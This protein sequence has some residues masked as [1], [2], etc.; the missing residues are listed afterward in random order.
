VNPAQDRPNIVIRQRWWQRGRKPATVVFG[1]LVLG[2]LLGL[3]VG[4]AM[5]WRFFRAPAQVALTQATGVQV[6]LEGE[7]GL[8]LFRPPL[9]QIE[10]LQ[11]AAA[12]GVPAGYLLRAS[13]VTLR[14]RWGDV[15]RAWRGG[16]IVIA[17]LGAQKLD[18]NLIRLMNGSATWQIGP[19]ANAQTQQ[20][21]AEPPHIDAFSL[22]EGLLRV[23]DEPVQ[24]RA[25]I[26][27]ESDTSGL[28][29]SANAVGTLRALSL[30]LHA[31]AEG[32][33]SEFD[34]Q[35]ASPTAPS[36]LQDAKSFAVRVEG[37]VGRSALAWAGQFSRPD[38][39]LA[40][41]GHLQFR[42]PSLAAVGDP[43]HISLPRTP[44]FDIAGELSFAQ[45]RWQLSESKLRVGSSQL[46][47]H[48]VFDTNPQPALL[49][50]RLTGS[51]LLFTDLAPAIGGAG[52]GG[53]EGG[54]S[55]AK[56]ASA[57]ST[58]AARVLPDRALDFSALRQMDADL[59][60]DIASVDFGSAAV[61]PL[62][63][64]RTHLRLVKAVLALESLQTDV[65]GGHLSGHTELDGRAD[66]AAWAG[67]LQF[68]GLDL[69]GFVRAVNVAPKAV[70][71][72]GGRAQ[73]QAR[74]PAD[75]IRLRAQRAK[76]R[77]AA[78]AASATPVAAYLT[79]ALNARIKLR[80]SGKSTAQILGSSQGQ[81]VASIS[82]GT[83]SHLMVEAAGLDLAQGLGVWLRGDRPLPLTC[84][85]V[86]LSVNNGVAT[87]AQGVLDNKDSSLQITG[88][89]SLKDETLDLRAVVHPK[90]VSLFTVRAPLRVG[91][92]FNAPAVSIEPGRI[93]GRVLSALALGAVAGPAALLP[94]VDLGD[95]AGDQPCAPPGALA[96]L[97]RRVGTGA[98]NGRQR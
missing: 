95:K 94:F 27:F 64:L 90:D 20:R 61:A 36:P 19:R 98:T 10:Q 40:L 11:V 38:R 83:V 23:V 72:G 46:G 97:A 43:L 4:E 2:L 33:A 87:V 5:Q 26:T 85:R 58:S 78:D 60:V 14:W 70:S 76:A 57:S 15:W 12:G 88:A 81:A 91:G 93:I 16:R 29:I 55:G 21:N 89:I 80:G 48:F 31:H 67:E 3:C 44:A 9:L 79:G 65:A 24:T 39:P 42:G 22:R 30:N 92:T 8:H 75:P 50:G 32:L 86:G 71:K 6:T 18:A 68:S 25:L 66:I 62:K 35:V 1:V 77:Q 82:Q 45:G 7:F 28:G 13:G 34:A 84:A 73:A 53:G 49:S 96:A 37:A 52:E 47:G 69:A 54:A 41:R 17:E 51:R 56:A 63:N 59:D 74:T